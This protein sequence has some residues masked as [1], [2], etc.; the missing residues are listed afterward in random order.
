MAPFAF[1]Q[2]VPTGIPGVVGVPS[3]PVLG[4][5][6]QAAAA[7]QEAA[8]TA[9]DQS[10]AA[11]AKKRAKKKPAKKKRAAADAEP[12][13]GPG[14]VMVWNDHAAA[15]KQIVLTSA[16]DPKK[17]T[18]FSKSLPAGAKAVVNLPAKGG[19]VYSVEGQFDDGTSIS[20]DSVEVCKDRS[21]NLTEQ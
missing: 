13:A 8:Q 3:S 16:S 14:Q 15:L 12:K 20:A 10:E 5:G 17:A 6:A 2:G 4:Q 19:C 11:P 9:G 1:A 18:L 21:L 7:A